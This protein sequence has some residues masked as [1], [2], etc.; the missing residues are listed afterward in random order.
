MASYTYLELPSGTVIE[1]SDPS[2][3]QEGKMLSNAEGRRRLRDEAATKLRKILPPGSTVYTTL[4]HVSRS[5]MTRHIGLI[6]IRNNVPDNIS[7]RVAR[8]LGMTFHHDGGVVASGGGMDMGF[9][10]VNNLSYALHGM[11][12]MGDGARPD[13]QGRPFKPRRGHF[14]AGYTLEHHWL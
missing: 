3:W 10:L 6:V 9:H 1:T 5:G 14:H 12:H 8:V 7:G 13:T 2:V 11:Q 4:L